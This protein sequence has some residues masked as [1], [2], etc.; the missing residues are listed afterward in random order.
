MYL[1]F[2]IKE[3]LPP[4]LTSDLLEKDKHYLNQFVFFKVFVTRQVLCHLQTGS[5]YLTLTYYSTEEQRPA[6]MFELR[7]RGTL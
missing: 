4:L 5:F 1:S 3:D 2:P 6:L 7:K